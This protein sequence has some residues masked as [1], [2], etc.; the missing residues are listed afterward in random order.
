MRITAVASAARAALAGVAAA[1]VWSLYRRLGQIASTPPC[2]DPSLLARVRAA[3]A[4]AADALEVRDAPDACADLRSLADAEIASSLSLGAP[5]A[6]ALLVALADAADNAP[7]SAASTGAIVEVRAGAGGKEASLFASELAAMYERFAENRR[8]RTRRIASSATSVGGVRE[9][10]ISVDAPAAYG[11]LRGEAGVHRVQRVPATESAGRVHTSTATVA[12]L[13]ALGRRSA[14][15]LNPADVRIDV[16]RASGAGGQHVNKTESA[17]RATHIPTGLVAIC[18][19]DRSQHRNRAV[20]LESLQARVDAQAEAEAAERRLGE[21]REQLGAATGD[22]SD[23]IRTYNF[24]QSRVTDHRIVPD[25]GLVALVPS[26]GKA[27]GEKSAPLA[28]V[29]RGEAELERIMDAVARM[30]ELD[31][32]RH[33]V[34]RSEA[35]VGEAKTVPKKKR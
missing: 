12:V 31:K 35:I 18:Q 14:I 16:F 8:W 27:A 11:L 2:V 10:V 1:D 13:R 24:P 7:S 4:S 22:R 33:L 6:A 5:D 34:L 21:R 3:D 32:V 23:R 26:A 20:A 17:V 28:A 9:V 29:L 19:D 30:R 25:A 15:E